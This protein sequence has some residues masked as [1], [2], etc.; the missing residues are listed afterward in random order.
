MQLL[1]ISILTG[2]SAATWATLSV[3]QS[4]ASHF[5]LAAYLIANTLVFVD[6]ID[7]LF[8]AGMMSFGSGNLWKP[9]SLM[10]ADSERRDSVFGMNRA[11]MNRFQ[12]R[13]HVKPWAIAV[14]VYNA[15]SALAEFLSSIDYLRDRIWIIDDGSSDGTCDYLRSIGWRCFRSV[16][17]FKKPGAIEKL[18]DNLPPEIATVIVIDPDIEITSR[19][20]LGLA[21]IEEV[22]F[23]F[24]QSG[25]SAICPRLAVRSESFMSKFQMLEYC[26]AFF[27]R[28]SLGKSCITSGISLYKRDTFAMMLTHHSKSVYAEDLENSILLLGMGHKVGSEYRLV[29]Q[30]EPKNTMSSWFSQRIGWSYGLIKVYFERFKDIR[31]ITRSSKMNWYQYLCYMGIFSL[32]L[33]PLKTLSL[34]VIAMSLF[35]GTLVLLGLTDSDTLSFFEPVYFITTFVKYCLLMFLTWLTVVPRNERGVLLPVLPVYL[36]YALLLTAAT[37]IGYLNWFSLRLIGH[38]LVRDHYDD[39][40]E[41]RFNRKKSVAPAWEPQE[42]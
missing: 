23:D 30:T 27:G 15:E 5:N 6:S 32:L 12:K 4:L 11:D 31:T 16:T 20:N 37:A 35:K 25:L 8:R 1:W 18:V 21:A 40:E 38:R 3:S 19:D 2:I 14:S 39:T 33:H 22:I 41:S 34:V 9:T 36:L 42:V 26:I 13:L 24:Q 28:R 17:N 10:D 7:L 29:I